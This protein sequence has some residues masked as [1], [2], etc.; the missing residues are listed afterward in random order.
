MIRSLSST[1]H[2]HPAAQTGPDSLEARG[3][4]EGAGGFHVIGGHQHVPVAVKAV[5]DEGVILGAVDAAVML[6]DHLP[7][8][9]GVHPGDLAELA[10]GAAFLFRG[11]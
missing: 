3:G 2:T 6:G 1:K 4:R 8:V 5:G 10:G 7:L 9:F 11:C